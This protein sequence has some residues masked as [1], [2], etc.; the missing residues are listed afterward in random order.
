MSHLREEDIP[1]PITIGQLEGVKREVARRCAEIAEHHAA[2]IP[3][4][5]RPEGWPMAE[6][7]A[8]AIRREFSLAEVQCPGCGE[9]GHDPGDHELYPE[10]F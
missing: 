7:I 6:R 8:D 2:R 5:T 3:G 9:P 4:V 1:I 10:E